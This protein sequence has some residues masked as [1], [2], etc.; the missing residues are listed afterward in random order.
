MPDLV[1]IQ[2]PIA[3][4]FLASLSVLHTCKL[5]VLIVSMLQTALPVSW[6]HCQAL[7]SAYIWV[8]EIVCAGNDPVSIY[9]RTFNEHE[10][11][12]RK[13]TMREQDGLFESGHSRPANDPFFSV[14]PCIY[15]LAPSNKRRYHGFPCFDRPLGVFLHS[16]CWL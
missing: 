2:Q 9:F 4:H 5:L 14:R 7:S 1:L 15:A 16:F 3:H 12:N 10:P 8:T 6:G 13:A 11:P